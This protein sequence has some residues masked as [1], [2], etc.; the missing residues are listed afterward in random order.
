M[1]ASLQLA[2]AVAQRRRLRNNPFDQHKEAVLHA[3][4][5]NSAYLLCGQGPAQQSNTFSS[6]RRAQDYEA[7]LGPQDFDWRS[8]PESP[9]VVRRANAR[10]E[11]TKADLDLHL[12]Q[13]YRISSLHTSTVKQSQ[14]E[15]EDQSIPVSSNKV[16]ESMVDAHQEIGTVRKQHGPLARPTL[17]CI[18]EHHCP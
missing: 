4:Y 16:D 17:R 7:G 15:R 6:Q 13:E 11:Q 14:G 8:L 2:E 3:I 10:T 1:N 5:Q 12:S 18:H 9:R